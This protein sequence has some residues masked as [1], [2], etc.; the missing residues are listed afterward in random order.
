MNCKLPDIVAKRKS[1]IIAV[2]VLKNNFK[3]MKKTKV[4]LCSQSEEQRR[5]QAKERFYRILK[6]KAED[7]K[8]KSTL[9]H[10][11]HVAVSGDIN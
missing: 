8:L 10:V 7:K 6:A 2:I 1:N 9:R 3:T 11:L 5:K 4:V